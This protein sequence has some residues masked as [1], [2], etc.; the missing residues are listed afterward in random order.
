MVEDTPKPVPKNPVI[1]EQERVRASLHA[2]KKKVGVHSGKGGVGKTFIACNLALLLRAD[3]FE[4]GLLDADVDC[5]NVPAFLNRTDDLEI[6]S[7]GRITPIVHHGVRIVS[8]GFV[9]KD[10][11]PFIVRGPIK[12]KVL[13][14]FFEK[15]QWGPLDYLIIDF[16][17]GTSDAPLSA[18]QLSGLDGVILVTTPQKESVADVRRA[19]GMARKL[20][21]PIIGLIENMAGE[22]FGSVGEELA[23]GL[24]IPFLGTIPLSHG[25]AQANSQGQAVLLVLEECAPIAKR[26]LAAVA[27]SPA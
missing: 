13:V 4:V 25:I 23:K 18:M 6:D 27:R 1:E 5:P 8:T 19:A 12:H 7:E 16:P 2:V 9:Q 20:G 22:V 21:V 3:G 11:E 26:L 14:D 17:P 24:A 15:T 10:D